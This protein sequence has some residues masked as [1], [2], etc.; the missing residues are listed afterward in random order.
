MGTGLKR[1]CRRWMVLMLVWAV[2]V[3]LVASMEIR[4]ELSYNE[5]DLAKALN[6]WKIAPG[7]L[8]GAPSG[9]CRGTL[10]DASAAHCPRAV[11]EANTG[12]V[13]AAFEENST[14]RKTLFVTISQGVIGYWLVP[15]IFIFAA[16]LLVAGVRRSLRRPSSGASR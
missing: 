1:W 3:T 4:D 5:A 7:A 13:N 8:D 11:I 14:R 2:P 15:G 9:S 6:N 12:L 16:G 10:Q